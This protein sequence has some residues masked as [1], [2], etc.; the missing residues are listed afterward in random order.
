MRDSADDLRLCRVV[1]G[2]LPGEAEQD[3]VA[4]VDAVVGGPLQQLEV[5]HRGGVLAH[6]LQ[7]V[8]AEALDAGLHRV[9]AAAA[10]LP[11]LL[12]G[13]LRAD[14]VVQAQVA[15]A[16]REP[17]E[18]P[19]H[20]RRRHD[21]VDGVE[22]P[23]AVAPGQR[24]QRLQHP[25][26]AR[27]PELHPG[28]VEAAERAVVLHPVPAAAPGLDRQ[29]DLATAPMVVPGARARREVLVEVRDRGGV[30][31]GHVGGPSGVLHLAVLAPHHPAQTGHRVALVDPPD[32]LRQGD[33][34]VTTVDVVDL[35]V[36]G[37]DLV[38]DVVLE[39]GPAEHDRHVRMP[40][41]DRLGQRE[42]GH[43][44]LEHD[45]EADETVGRPV[46]GLGHLLDELRGAPFPQ[47][48]DVVDRAAGPLADL[49]QAR[50]V[51]PHVLVGVPD[52]AERGRRPD[53]LTD[54]ARVDVG[55][56]LVQL[57]ADP[58]AE[59]QEQRHRLDRV[60][61]PF[62]GRG[63]QSELERREAGGEC[64]HAHQRDRFHRC[65]RRCGRRPSR[66]ASAWWT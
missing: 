30:Q 38:R 49:A 29:H 62:Q 65:S 64:R 46:D 41:S 22:V 11:E 10:H 27:A 1:L 48:D 18:Q 4:V 37:D 52:L 61:G 25:L 5:A 59:A 2:R 7:H 57:P 35:R 14:L 23:G 21:V 63:E 24:L 13:Q 66:A 40:A 33:V 9:Q 56:R 20:V 34:G 31:I 39:R 54:H 60:S 16:V 28:P 19:G 55:E 32:H 15:V 58:L 26:R 51:A 47:R 6:Q 3:V 50:V 43:H 12:A 53:P 44:L 8:R 36:A 17:A 42:R 45:R